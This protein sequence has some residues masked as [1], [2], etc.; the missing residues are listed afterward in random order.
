MK[1]LR[2]FRSV[3]QIPDKLDGLRLLAHNL[4]WSWSHTTAELFRALDPDLWEQ[5]EHNPVAL[6]SRLSPEALAAR[7][8]DDSF[9]FRVDRE[10]A[11]LRQY[12]EEPTW[13][14]RT[15][16][17]ES[18]QPQ[19]AYFCAEYGLTAWFRIYSGGL[20][21]LAGDHLKAASDL[22]VPL[23]AVG[24][25]Y[26]RGYFQQR[27]S[28]DGAQM[29]GYPFKDA[30]QLPMEIVRQPGGEPLL[31]EVLIRDETVRAQVWRVNVGRIS[32]Y[33]LDT[34]IAANPPQLRSI[35]D[36]LYVGDASR[37]IAQLLVLGVGGIR[38]LEAM[39]IR[40]SVYHLNEGHAAFLV[41]E[42]L[43]QY[44]VR[45]IPLSTATQ[46][47]QA[48]NV[49][50]T[51]T[52]VPAGNQTFAVDLVQNH[53]APYLRECGIRWEDFLHWGQAEAGVGEFG[54]TVLCLRFST[55]ANGVSRLHGEVARQ[56]WEKVWRGVPLAETP[57]YHVT[58]G[59]HVATWV[60][61]EMAD[62]YDT[63]LDP[64]WRTEPADH[65]VW[66]RVDE[67]PAPELWRAHERSRERLVGAARKRL[68]RQL[69]MR[70]ASASEL[71]AASEVLDPSTLTIGF[72]RRFAAYKRAT[73]ILR[74]PER[75]IAILTNPSRPVQLLFAGKSHPDDQPGKDIIREFAQFA[76][77]PEVRHHIVFLEDYDMHLA[78]LLVAGVDVWLNTPLRPHE[79]S[80][81]SGM[82][83]AFNGVLNASILDGWWD[84]A[85]G[86]T[87]DAGLGEIGWAIGNGGSEKRD[88]NEAA[89]LDS[90]A[91]Y[92]VLEREIVPLFYERGADDIP[93]EWVGR[94]KRSIRLLAPRFNTH[95]MVMDYT[96][97]A[98]LPAAA[99]TSELTAHNQRRARALGE[100]K[101]RVRTQWQKVVIKSVET[102][103]GETVVAGTPVRIR[104]Q[105][106]LDGLQPSDV[107]AQVAVGLLNLSDI[108]APLDAVTYTELRSVAASGSLVAF[109]GS[110]VCNLSGHVG[111][112]VRLLPTHPDLSHPLEL[113]LVRWAGEELPV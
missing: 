74:N 95:R 108:S 21:V 72:A 99:R 47:V 43:R 42:R 7:A 60:S 81:T 30:T 92:S 23:V 40:P 27:L 4:W 6:L 91:L 35:T 84:E 104:V 107:T 38:A 78:S 98:Y 103:A 17:G 11:A 54:M 45:G 15:H 29:E 113:G 88:E 44:V 49:F 75:L 63:Y 70:Y 83:A 66:S 37:R 36:R 90:A 1:P 2:S 25:F 14:A 105:A 96:K 61:D 100:W 8:N 97:D 68:E 112:T 55:Y 33:L 59:T 10:V 73:L 69:S 71:R 18:H 56:M 53:L 86:D 26:H 58:N 85:Y 13:F 3:P 5:V 111:I 39:G 89:E 34:N 64:R 109:E 65:S 93:R 106:E 101:D 62:V 67:I 57:I 20:G 31:V 32:L 46:I 80:G 94:M 16:P 24:L 48:S 28:H 50:T 102:D 110:F 77:R 87:E 22:G 41:V 52:P 19:I 82:K 12:L 9:I 79:A 76:Q 51:H